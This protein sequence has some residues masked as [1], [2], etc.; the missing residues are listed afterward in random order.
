MEVSSVGVD[1]RN[2]ASVTPSAASILFQIPETAGLDLRSPPVTRGRSQSASTA[3]T[4]RATVHQLSE[5]LTAFGKSLDMSGKMCRI[6][7]ESDV[8]PAFMP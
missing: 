6:G 8:P 1:A 2:E 5:T 7:V 4:V 3:A